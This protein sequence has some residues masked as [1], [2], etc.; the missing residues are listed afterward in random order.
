MAIAELLRGDKLARTASFKIAFALSFVTWVLPGCLMSRE[1]LLTDALPS[2]GGQFEVHLY[3]DFQNAKAGDFHVATYRW[4]DGRYVRSSGSARDAV[5]FAVREL[6]GDDFIIQSSSGPEKVFNYWIGRR[7]IPGVY[8]MVPIDENDVDAAI[9]STACA[10]E[11]PAYEIC[12]VE[13]YDHLVMLARG[14]ASKPLRDPALGVILPR[15]AI[16]ESR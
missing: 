8:L 1:P 6:G 10:K 5:N 7:V 13:T 14:T 12:R 16:A 3:E 2:L 15:T 11:K 9:R 4:E